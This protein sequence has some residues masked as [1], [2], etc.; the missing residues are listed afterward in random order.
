M[1]DEIR[2]ALLRH[3]AD[4]LDETT[5]NGMDS[6]VEP[7]YADDSLIH[8]AVSGSDYYFR[9]SLTLTDPPT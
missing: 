4:R 1:V 2:A 8:V 5:L 7:H 9:L 3:I 6:F